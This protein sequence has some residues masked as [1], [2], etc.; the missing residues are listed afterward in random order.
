[1]ETVVFWMGKFQ[2]PLTFCSDGIWKKS[3]HQ[4]RSAKSSSFDSWWFRTDLST[5]DPRIYLIYKIIPKCLHETSFQKYYLHIWLPEWSSMLRSG[6]DKG[7]PPAQRWTLS[8]RS[9]TVSGPILLD[10]ALG[11]N[12]AQRLAELVCWVWLRFHV[13][14]PC[15]I[16]P[17]V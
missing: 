13:D 11:G 10:E 12:R 15:G 2:M 1:M 16:W 17:P 3:G 8:T 6:W 4:Y 14:P 7:D 9:V 5:L